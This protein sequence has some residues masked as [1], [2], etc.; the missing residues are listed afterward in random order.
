MPDLNFKRGLSTENQ[1]PIVDGQIIYHTDTSRFY[2]DVNDARIEVNA[3]KSNSINIPQIIENINTIAKKLS[4]NTEAI[5]VGGS[6]AESLFG[7]PVNNCIIN[8][9]KDNTHKV[10]MDCY[11][12]ENGNHFISSCQNVNIDYP[13]WTEWTL[14]PNSSNTYTKD[15]I[16]NIN[17]ALVKEGS[18]IDIENGSS[19]EMFFYTINHAEEGPEEGFV[20]GNSS[21]NFTI[22]NLTID[23]YG[24][25]IE[26][27]KGQQFIIADTLPAA[28]ADY[29][30]IICIVY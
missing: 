14:Q 26:A 8:I 25:T 19:N 4:L 2:F 5:Y 1:P 16:E 22:P 28:S 11:E 20:H 15:E 13:Q 21:T 10:L 7:C 12:L 27:I 9:K 6:N 29:N 23:N 30:G 18:A 17:K 24:H 3:N